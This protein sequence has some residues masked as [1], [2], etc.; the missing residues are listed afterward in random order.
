VSWQP[1]VLDPAQKFSVTV[2]GKVVCKNIKATECV[3]GR[4]LTAKDVVLVTINGKQVAA[5]ID[6]AKLKYTGT[7]D[8]VPYTATLAPGAKTAL[9]ATAKKLLAAGFKKVVVTGHANPVAN[10]PL[11]IS[12]KLA[13]QRATVVA[14]ALRKLLPNLTVIAVNRSIYTPIKSGATSTVQN[15]RAEVYGTN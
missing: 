12:S 2:N 10:V 11:Y 8:F 3:V 1:S 5:S 6:D 4:I 15:I 13:A 7:V 14:A 9:V